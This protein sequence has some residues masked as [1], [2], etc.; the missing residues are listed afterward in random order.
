[1]LPCWVST[2]YSPLHVVFGGLLGLL[3]IVGG[4]FLLLKLCKHGRANLEY[5]FKGFGIS[6]SADRFKKATVTERGE[7]VAVVPATTKESPVSGEDV[8]ARAFL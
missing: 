1:M 3:I 4:V 7:F 6:D 8:K 5:P 2:V